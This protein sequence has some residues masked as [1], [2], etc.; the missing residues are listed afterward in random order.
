[1]LSYPVDKFIKWLFFGN[2]FYG[3]CAVALSIEAGLQQR[4]PLNDLFFYILIFC[5]T[6]LYYS[7]TYIF[8]E[9]SVDISNV[10]SAWYAANNRSIRRSQ[11]FLLLLFGSVGIILLSRIWPQLIHMPTGDWALIFLFPAVAILY[12]GEPGSL[13]HRY[14]LRNIGWLKPFIIGFTWAGVVTVYPVLYHQ[15]RLE[16]GYELTLVGFFLFIK[17]FMYIT[18]LC[19]MFDI[20]DYAMDY[21][22]QLKTF[23]VKHGLR[24]TIFFIII[25]LCVAGL[26]SYIG[27]AILHHFQPLKIIL[28]TIPFLLALVVA[29]SLQLRQSILYYLI[30]IDGLMLV[31]AICGITAMIYF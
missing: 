16:Q 2:Y 5:A 28:N 11:W 6:V 14:N 26:G 1:M 20:K 18:V 13:L 3:L 27:Y 25:P 24:N 9:T 30:I 15:M 10:R 21:N 17:N 23:V 4:F 7:K 8:T 31:K 19:I 29:Y 22:R 12:Y